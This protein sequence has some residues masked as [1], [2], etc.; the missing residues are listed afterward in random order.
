MC[1]IWGA[2][3]KQDISGQQFEDVKVKLYKAYNKIKHR[4]PDRHEYK[5]FDSPTNV[6]F[7]FHRLAIVSTSASDDQ[8]MIS[9][10]GQRI[11]CAGCNG[12]IYEYKA[13]AEK[14]K[15][16]LKTGS[17]CEVIPLM[18]Q[19]YGIKGVEIMCQEFD[20]EHAFVILDIDK[21]T[22]NYTIIFSEDRFG[23]RPLF[24]AED[25][26]GIYFSSELIGI[27]CLNDED[28]E[29]ERFL[30]RNYAVLQKKQ[31][32]LGKLEYTE[33]CNLSSIKQTITDLDSALKL[34]NQSFR[35]AVLA[36]MH[37]A[38]PI[39]CLLSGGLDSSLTSALVAEQLAKQGKKLRTFT[40]GLAGATDK[41]F[42]EAVAKQIGSIH[43]HVE[44]KEEDFLNALEDIVRITGT[45]DI[46]TIRA[47]TGQYLI[48]K[49]VAENTD[50]KVLFLGDGM[51][52]V[53]N[54]Y[55]YSHKAP[56]AQVLHEDAIRLLNDIHK[57]D[58]LRADRAC[59]NV[60]IEARFPALS[61]GFVHTYLSV[62]PKLRTP[63][64]KNM[65]KWLLREAFAK[66]NLLPESV[67][68]RKK[69]AFSDG[70]SSQQKSWKD[71][72]IEKVEKIYTDSEASD[73]Y[74]KYQHLPPI[75]KE[76]LYY[77]E[78]FCKY[79]ATNLSVS[80]T[81]PY[82]WLPRWCGDVKDPSARVLDVYSEKDKK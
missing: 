77:R 58:G 30:P 47:T 9:D 41:P 46:T 2:L 49:W 63:A 1:G 73:K 13:F 51:D 71:M 8:P 10:D 38:R 21:K 39:G 69:E 23:I 60:G 45:I 62:D 4:G 59:A 42:A 55:L 57:Y 61:Y 17:D 56:N 50:I 29:V 68:W 16:E 67:L 7:G 31:G 70:C 48:C 19:K 14:Y 26:Y 28:A 76:S 5:E 3:L 11:I 81:I 74:K 20:S 72:I 6:I 22:G 12:E 35:Q 24:F 40:I 18:Y 64:Y 37:S 34:V 36:R 78:L 33:Y 66:D 82:Y 15:L 75:S 44:F 79:Y 65:E 25:K 32:Q 52:E 53:A 27:P 80:K 43:T 54:G